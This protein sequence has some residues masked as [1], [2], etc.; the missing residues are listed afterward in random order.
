MR[1]VNHEKGKMMRDIRPYKVEMFRPAGSKTP[2]SP[3][4]AT[5]SVGNLFHA[6]QHYSLSAACKNH[7]F[8]NGR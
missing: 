5:F 7:A 3:S 4:I 6:N 8:S 2:S 1:D